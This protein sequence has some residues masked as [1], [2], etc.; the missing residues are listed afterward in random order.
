MYET[1]ENRGRIRMSKELLDSYRS[2]PFWS[3][4]DKLEKG[5]LVRQIRGMEKNGIGGFF[6]HARSGLQTEYLSEEWMQCIE[7]CAEEAQE[8][9]MKA[10]I[11]DE[12][13]WP[14]GFAG[15]KLLEDEKN[16]DKYVEMKEGAFDQAATV[17]YLLTEDELVRVSEPTQ[18]DGTYLNVYIRTA[19]STADILNPEVVDK[20]LKLT[21]E[22]YKERFGEEFSQK[23][24]GFFTDEPQYQRWNTPYTDMIASYFKEKY[25]EDILDS[26]GLLFVEKKGYRQFRYRYWKGMQELMLKNFAEKVYCWCEENGVKLT[27]HYV[28]ETTMG[29]QMMC[30]GG[31]MPFYEFEHIPGIDWLGK[32]TDTVLATV[33]VASAAAQMGKKQ[34][35]TETFG[36]CGWD[37]TPAELRRIAGYQYVHG[38][39]LM[40][41]HLVPYT[42]RGLRKHDYPAHYSEINPWI[43]EEFKTFN[44]YFTRLGYLIGEGKQDVKVAVLHPIRSAYFNYKRDLEGIGFGVVELDEALR[45]ANKML[46]QRGIAY[47][48]LDETLLAKYGFAE[49]GTIGC[50]KCSYQYLVLPKIYTMDK[51]TE[52]LVRRFVEQGGKVLLLDE[53]PSYLE[54]ET[55]DYP[56]LASN[57]TLE[58]IVKDMPFHVE[59]TDADL[60]YTYRT[61]EDKKYV[62]V[63]NASATETF[64][65]KFDFGEEVRSFERVHLED[66]SSEKISMELELK[67]GEDALLFLSDEPAEERKALEP[68]RLQFEQAEIEFEENALAVD[69]VRYSY[70]GEHY[71]KPWPWSALFQKLIKE[72]Y[73]GNIFLRYEFEVQEIPKKI[74]LKAEENND[75]HAWFNDMLLTEKLEEGEAYENVYDISDYVKTGVNTYTVE[76][77]WHEDELVHYALY[78][79]NVTESLKNCIVYDS[80]LQ[81]I[82]IVGHFGVY[83]KTGYQDTEKKYVEAND[84]YIG[85]VPERASNITVEGFPFL[86]GEIV[87]SQKVT[88]DKKNILLQ[89]AGDYQMAKVTVNG[90][91]KST[92]LFD[93][94]VDISDV[95][96]VG[97]NEIQVRFWISNRN[98]RGPHHVICPKDWGVSPWSFE[99]AGTWEEDKNEY[100]HD[101][102]DLKLFYER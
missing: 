22:Q 61:L 56:Y 79:E 33:Q 32:G 77:K 88:F 48:Y 72:K 85:K 73:E 101:S 8:Q 25:Q 91:E 75:I 58:D 78:G 100:Y 17:S 40:C 89:V 30:C 11:Y 36:C 70:D 64:T 18:A 49:D 97:E 5:E 57:C 24:E 19:T 6:M 52:Q 1:R 20:F 74:R 59:N 53:K 92:L 13:G 44:D 28:E 67:P 47:H 16:R 3:W 68:Y 99:L 82:Y 21:H 43:R 90:V 93:K 7:A 87:L 62:Y 81:P 46:E 86:A 15:G 26:L 29:Y 94:E 38:V 76:V 50:G 37:V 66:L 31:V 41:H 63:V 27:G 2:I 65:Q 45:E 95:A 14:S 84:F 60:C 55:F 12:N 42:E 69:C 96:V 71:S 35:I 10:W 34:V 80:E 9:N 23:I 83:P 39:N 4:N 51:T 98:L 102:Y 54:A